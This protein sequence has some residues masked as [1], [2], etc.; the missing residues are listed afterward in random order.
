[1]KLAQHKKIVKALQSVLNNVHKA[2]DVLEMTLI[3]LPV[4]SQPRKKRV[5]RKK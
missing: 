2:L 5:T 4:K 1:M 3:D